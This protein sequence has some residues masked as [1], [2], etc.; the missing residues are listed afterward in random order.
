M[1]LGKNAVMV[2]RDIDYAAVQ[3]LAIVVPPQRPIPSTDIDTEDSSFR[4]W[5][6]LRATKKGRQVAEKIQPQAAGVAQNPLP[7]TRFPTPVEPILESFA[8]ILGS[9]VRPARRVSSL[10][11]SGHSIFRGTIG[12]RDSP[13]PPGGDTVQIVSNHDNADDFNTRITC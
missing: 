1:L 9:I 11:F 2:T 13:H 8:W 10:V 4:G 7:K 6:L 5:D 3:P 12:P